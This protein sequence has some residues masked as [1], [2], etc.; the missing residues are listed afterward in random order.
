[1]NKEEEISNRETHYEEFRNK[2]KTDY[3][4]EGGYT[5][6]ESYPESDIFLIEVFNKD[7]VRVGYCFTKME[8]PNN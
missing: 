8:Y 5:F 3:P 6:Q 4:I 1:M 2:V 7:G